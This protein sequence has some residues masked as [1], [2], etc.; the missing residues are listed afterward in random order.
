MNLIILYFNYFHH[1]AIAMK[2]FYSS[3]FT[4]SFLA[5]SGLAVVNAKETHQYPAEFVQNYNQECI[6]TSMGEGLDEAEAKKLCNCTLNKF[7]QQYNLE[8]F[9]RLTATAANDQKAQNTLVEVGQVCF[10][11]ILYEQ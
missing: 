8:E 4:L 3:L 2:Y 1:I 7:Q 9:K 6:Q 10:E 11:Q 5:V